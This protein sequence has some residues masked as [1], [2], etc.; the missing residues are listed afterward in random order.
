VKRGEFERE[1]KPLCE[2]A[3]IGVI[4]YSPL[5]AGFLTGKYQPGAT[6]PRSARASGV[7]RKYF[8]DPVA[9]RTLAVSDEIAKAHGAAVS[10]VAIAWLLAQP[11]ITAPIIGA[12]NTAQ[13]T[14]SLGALNLQLSAAELTRLNNASGGSYSWND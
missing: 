2:D 4:P 10:Q 11:A 7:Q 8:D 5:A 9:W 1:L 13:L 12:N 14:E 6:V 3:Q